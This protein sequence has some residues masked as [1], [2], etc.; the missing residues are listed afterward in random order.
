MRRFRKISK[1]QNYIKYFVNP[2]NESILRGKS[3]L[4]CHLGIICRNQYMKY[5]HFLIFVS[6]GSVFFFWPWH[7]WYTQLLFCCWIDKHLQWYPF[8]AYSGV[9]YKGCDAFSKSKTDISSL[10]VMLISVWVL[11]KPITILRQFW[12]LMV[13]RKIVA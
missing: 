2:F 8:F 4:K 5:H 3:V 1:Y 10:L 9:V 11:Y 12:P 13:I 6:N 7:H